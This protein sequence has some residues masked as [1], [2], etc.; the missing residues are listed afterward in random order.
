MK[1]KSRAY[2]SNWALLF[3]LV[4][5]WG[6]SFILMKKGLE[7]YSYQEVALLR[8]AITC[9]FLLP[10]AIRSIKKVTAKKLGLMTIV[11]V[12]G[13]GIPAFLFTKAE[14]GI[15][16]TLAGIL[17]SLTPLFTLIIGVLFFK[18]KTKWYN[19]LGVFIG[20]AGT[21]GLMSVSGNKSLE[22]NFSYGIYVIIATVLYAIN[23]NVVK[24]YL[25]EVDPVTIT[26]YAFLT[27]GIPS[28]IYLFANTDF[29]EIIQYKPR[30]FV[31]LGYIAILGILGTAIA[32]F[33]YYKLIKTSS[34]L[35]AASV[36]YMMPIVAV[37]WGMA[38]GEL[39]KPV[40]VI[41]ILIILL[42]VFLVNYTFN[43]VPVK[44]ISP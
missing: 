35:F 24:T 10:F 31:G 14:T 43:K 2:L 25:K 37:L 41:W 32:L 30:A 34:V 17:N 21:V 23:L 3:T 1:T 12:V 8:I 11:G 15:D 9:L 39:F 33:L 19:V 5:I 16:S 38:D 4:L 40:Y 20:L 28:I 42:G 27:I 26:S 44:N 6:S 36:T 29:V 7:Q 18:S 13:N 22:F